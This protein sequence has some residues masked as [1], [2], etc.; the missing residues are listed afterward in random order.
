MKNG[1]LELLPIGEG[2]VRRE[3]RD[4]VLVGIGVVVQEALAAAEMLERE[5]I[6]AA[7]INAR[8]LKPLDR[9]LLTAWAQKTGRVV[10][11]EENALAGGFGSAVLEMLQE[12]GLSGIPVLRLGLPDRFITHGTRSELLVH[13]GLDGE[14]IAGSVKAWLEKNDERR[15]P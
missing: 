5:G 7:V 10:T 14:G 8:F 1:Q 4:V 6:S 11:I 9:R 12:E 15:T 2:E 13:V 3:G